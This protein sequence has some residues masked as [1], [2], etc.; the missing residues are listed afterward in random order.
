M[1]GG[2]KEFQT[3]IK[4]DINDDYFSVGDM[5]IRAHFSDATIAFLDNAFGK[6]GDMKQLFQFY[7]QTMGKKEPTHIEVTIEKNPTMARIIKN[8][9][10]TYLGKKE[11]IIK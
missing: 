5:V 4:V 9:I 3:G 11:E 8:Q 7:F 10:L 6:I 1:L 2:I